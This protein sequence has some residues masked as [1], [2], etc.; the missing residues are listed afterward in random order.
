V[1]F[2]DRSCPRRE[3]AE[4]DRLRDFTCRAGLAGTVRC[5]TRQALALLA[6]LLGTL[7]F[8]FIHIIILAVQFVFSLP[9]GLFGSALVCSCSCTHLALRRCMSS[10][11]ACTNW[12]LLCLP[13]FLVSGLCQ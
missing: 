13:A 5:P 1:P 6:C 11:A 2:V 7:I 12:P 10:S 9:D 4:L 8:F 3:C